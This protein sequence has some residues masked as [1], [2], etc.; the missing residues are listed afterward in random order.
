VLELVC[1]SNK[2]FAASSCVHDGL[3]QL[4]QLLPSK[5]TCPE[6]SSSQHSRP[7]ATSFRTA[8]ACRPSLRAAASRLTIDA[9]SHASGAL[10][11]FI[12]VSEC[13]SSVPVGSGW[14]NSTLDASGLT[15]HDS[16]G[17]LHAERSWVL[18]LAHKWRHC[19]T[20]NHPSS[21]QQPRHCTQTISRPRPN[22]TQLSDYSTALDLL[23]LTPT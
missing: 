22:T 3:D 2:H 6:V 4:L 20:A 9:S 14:L 16:A 18:D 23:P 8:S 13:S 12:H 17:V 19:L 21:L 10:T 15:Q 1:A 5:R 11:S 7:I